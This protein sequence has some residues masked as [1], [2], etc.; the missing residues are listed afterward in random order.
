MLCLFA[1]HFSFCAS[2]LRLLFYEFVSFVLRLSRRFFMFIVGGCFSVDLLH[3]EI[4][5]EDSN[6]FTWIV[7]YC[8]R[9][10]DKIY[11]KLLLKIPDGNGRKVILRERLRSLNEFVGGTA[12]DPSCPFVE[13]FRFIF[14]WLWWI[15][16]SHCKS[17]AKLHGK[18]ESL[19]TFVI[20]IGFHCSYLSLFVIWRQV[21]RSFK[22]QLWNV[23]HLRMD[24]SVYSMSKQKL[25]EN[26]I[27]FVTNLSSIAT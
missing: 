19:G 13:C 21:L 3:F 24:S 17:T 9:V 4:Q 14:H 10:C 7:T 11:D 15:I 27:I 5:S 23:K 18:C 2:F 6:Y 25:I 8:D 26:C 12:Q 16:V 22:T 1:S 20:Y